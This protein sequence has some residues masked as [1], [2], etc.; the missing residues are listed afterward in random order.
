[1]IPPPPF[2][3]LWNAVVLLRI[4]VILINVIVFG[5]G[6]ALIYDLKV[7]LSNLI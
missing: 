6:L 4:S 2:F 3:G 1:M 7:E 5:T